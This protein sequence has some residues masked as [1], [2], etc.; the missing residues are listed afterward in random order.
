MAMDDFVV[1]PI[2]VVI[3]VAVCIPLPT[4]DDNVTFKIYYFLFYLLSDNTQNDIYTATYSFKDI[5]EPFVS[6]ELRC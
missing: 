4:N 6:L 2:L 1:F 5:R 3:R